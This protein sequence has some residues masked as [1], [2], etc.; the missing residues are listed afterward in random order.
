MKIYLNLLKL[1]IEYCRL[2]FPDT[3]SIV[4]FGFVDC[5]CVCV[6]DKVNNRNGTDTRSVCYCLFCACCK[7]QKMNCMIQ[8]VG[9]CD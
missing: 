9:Y 2:F 4:M 7:L 8:V 3:V 1:C 6:I 5:V